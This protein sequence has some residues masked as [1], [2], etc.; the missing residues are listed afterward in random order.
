MKRNLV[1]LLI[2]SFALL[3]ASCNSSD[4]DVQ[5]NK[6]KINDSIDG[7]SI[8]EKDESQS[9]IDAEA[10]E[11]IVTETVKLPETVGEV[12]VADNNNYY[13]KITNVEIGEYGLDVSVFFQNRM[14]CDCNVFVDTKAYINNVKCG[15]VFDIDV[16]AGENYEK[17]DNL[18]LNDMN[19]LGIDKYTDIEIEFTVKPDNK[20]IP[21]TVEVAHVYPFGKE[22]A[23]PFK[24]ELKENDT[25]LMDNEYV[26][27]TAIS[28]EFEPGNG[29]TAYLFIE[30]K[31]D[32]ELFVT[33]K[34]AYV[35]GI[36]VGSN[37]V[38]EIFPGKT[39]LGDIQWSK[40]YLEKYG[41][42]D[43]TSVSLNLLIYDANTG[44][45][46]IEQLVSFN[47]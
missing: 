11:E 47:P 9:T 1:F 22:N 16:P 12:V 3:F 26:T 44:V 27:I 41:V 36:E 25:V 29:Y 33:T 2:C 40:S 35:S 17:T 42:T 31:S 4:A 32:K 5:D 38:H 13:L 46:Y 15:S 21:K 10:K 39:V 28:H 45:D 8:T 20:N 18:P 37:L 43:I 7:I 24:Y 34:N 19:F 6:D 23:V 30:N 14:E